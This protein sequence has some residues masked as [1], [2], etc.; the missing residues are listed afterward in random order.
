MSEVSAAKQVVRSKQTSERCMQMSERVAPFFSL[1]SCVF[2]PPVGSPVHDT[3]D[4]NS[5]TIL[6]LLAEIK[7]L[8]LHKKVAYVAE[9]ILRHCATAPHGSIIN[10][11]DGQKRTALHEGQHSLYSEP[12]FI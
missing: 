1:H 6:H 9:A 3:T 12:P 10:F 4:P 11:Q 5:R 7:S 2:W 8:F